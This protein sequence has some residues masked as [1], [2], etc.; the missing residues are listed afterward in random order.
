MLAP[1]DIIGAPMF[2]QARRVKQDYFPV[3]VRRVLVDLDAA[4]MIEIQEIGSD[5]DPADCVIRSGRYRLIIAEMAA[6]SWL[7]QRD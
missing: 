3:V 6:C 2:A 4:D 7:A 1:K 5:L